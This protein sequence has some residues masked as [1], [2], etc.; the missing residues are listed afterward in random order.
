MTSQRAAQCG[1]VAVRQCI[2]GALSYLHIELEH[3]ENQASVEY[4]QT[5]AVDENFDYPQVALSNN[6]GCSIYAW[7]CTPLQ[8]GCTG[9]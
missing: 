1:I 7:L 9:S 4:V 8:I 2:V 3:S 5:H 6:N